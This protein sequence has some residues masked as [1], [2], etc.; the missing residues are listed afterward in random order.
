MTLTIELVDG[1]E[2]SIRQEAEKYSLTTA[3][4]AQFRIQGFVVRD[5]SPF[6]PRLPGTPEWTIDDI[7]RVEE[8]ADL[9]YLRR[10]ETF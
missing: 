7:K 6:I 9:E 2:E 10:Y 8:E 3:E 5:G 1:V 4:Y